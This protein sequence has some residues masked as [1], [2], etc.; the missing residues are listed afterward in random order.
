MKTISAPSP[1][2]DNLDGRDADLDRTS[3]QVP[4]S[5]VR[6]V[7]QAKLLF[8]MVRD[9]YNNKYVDV[10]W[11]T[12][13]IA[14]AAVLY[15]LSPVDAIPDIF[16]LIGFTD[17]AAVLAMTVASLRADLQNYVRWRKLNPDDYFG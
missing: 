8:Q 10:P 15:F 4:G 2:D 12:I 13:G 1:S 11:R 7:R 6:L 17:D 3:R 16:P 5:L 14:A 9:F